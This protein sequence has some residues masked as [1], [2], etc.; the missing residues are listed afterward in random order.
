MSGDATVEK[1]LPRNLALT[2]PH[3]IC[4]LQTSHKHDSFRS[5]HNKCTVDCGFVNCQFAQHFVLFWYNRFLKSTL[6]SELLQR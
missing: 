3:Q 6:L 1:D 4:C 2:P 5:L